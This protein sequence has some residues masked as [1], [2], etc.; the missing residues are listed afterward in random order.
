M[1]RILLIGLIVIGGLPFACD[2]GSS[3]YESRPYK[4]DSIG[5]LAG[6][7]ITSNSY[8]YVAAVEPD[9]P[10]VSTS[11]GLQMSVLST[12]SVDVALRFG[13]SIINRAF[14][15]LPI[16]P[17]VSEIAQIEVFASDTL[18]FDEGTYPAGQTITELFSAGSN[19]Y[20]EFETIDFLVVNMEN[21][22]RYDRIILELK[23]EVTSEFSGSFSVKVLM[24][25][26]DLFEVES[27]R[28]TIK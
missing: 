27:E 10:I 3:N 22:D 16:P 23:E 20:G 6:K 26:G 25:D 12:K 18:F 17:S 11:F 14:A 5:V 7:L 28:V 4:I 8:E 9:E 13:I 24:E 21:W 19:Y 15:D 1:K 2:F